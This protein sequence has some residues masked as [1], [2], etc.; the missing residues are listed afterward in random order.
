MKVS[1]EQRSVA[2][3]R[4]PRVTALFVKPE[5]H[6]P[7]LAVD[8]VSARRNLGLVGDAHAQPLGPRQ[9][10]VVREETCAEV[11]AT[12]AQ[13]RANIAFSGLP[14]EALSSGRVLRVGGAQIR[15]THECEVCKVL[16]EY[17]DTETFKH[18]PGRRGA[19]GVFLRGGSF[20]IGDPVSLG[21][22]RFPVVPE[23]VSQ[24]AGWVI[25]RIPRGRVI[26]YDI[27]LKLIGVK[28]AHYRVLPTYVRMAH[29]AGLPAHRV[30]TSTGQL[31]GHVPAQRTALD[32]EGVLVDGEGFLSSRSEWEGRTLFLEPEGGAS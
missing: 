30:L 21:R 32:R 24:R 15:L 26:R 31:T 20:G 25:Q 22:R 10:L 2:D 4:E 12:P 6:R 19:L 28:R 18:L 16:R 23:V 13:L 27:L 17:V 1:R 7:A 8:R 14:D 3:I 5:R 11:G 9:V 29:Q